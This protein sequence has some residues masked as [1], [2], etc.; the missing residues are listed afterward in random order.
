MIISAMPG[1]VMIQGASIMY[2]RPSAMMLPQVGVGG[3]APSAE[4][5]Q[6]RLGQHRVGE[7]EA[8][9]HDQRRHRV[10]QDVAAQDAPVPRAGRDRRLHI[11]HLAQHDHRGAHDARGA[12]D[13]D[14]GQ[15]EDGVERWMA[16]ARR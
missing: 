16:R 4:E 12:R 7:Q 1:M 10:G 5:A 9:L 6:R 3:T 13:I 14:D 2:W 11:F 15:R 8:Q